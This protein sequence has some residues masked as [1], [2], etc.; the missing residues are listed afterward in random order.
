MPAAARRCRASATVIPTCW[1]PCTLS[2]TIWPMRTRAFS[3]RRSPKSWREDLIAHAPPGTSHVYFVSGGSEAI[4]AC[5]QDGAA[6]FRGEGRAAAPAL[7][8]PPA[9]LSR[10]HAGRL[11][12]RRQRMAPQAVRTAADRRASCLAVLRVSR[13]AAGRD[14]GAVRRAAGPGTRRQDPRARPG[15]RHGLRG[16]NGRRRDGR[17]HS[18]GRG[19]LQAHPRDLRPPRHPADPGRGDVRHGPHGHAACLRAGRH[20]ARPDGHCQGARRRLRADRGRSRGRE[21]LRGLRAG[22]RLLPARPHLPRPSAGVRRAR[23][24]CSGSSGATTCSPM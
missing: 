2:S 14:A 17:M 18:A 1:P 11:G 9:E 22:L 7:H 8:R 24:P 16:R 21:G 4:E 19:L 3:R 15:Y 23:S 10:Q 6:V 12:R 5:A 20:R 13:A